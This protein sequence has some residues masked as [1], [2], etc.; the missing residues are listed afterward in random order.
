MRNLGITEFCATDREVCEI[1]RARR[2][3]TMRMKVR[4]WTEKSREG[5]ASDDIRARAKKHKV[6][7][8][9][10]QRCLSNTSYFAVSL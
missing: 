7:S 9:R 3:E 8:G 4:R 10:G 2:A 1:Y 5:G 6:R